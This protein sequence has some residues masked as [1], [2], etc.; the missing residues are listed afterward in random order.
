MSNDIA[1][2]PVLVKAIAASESRFTGSLN[3]ESEKVFAYDAITKNDNLAKVAMSNPETLKLAMYN[4]AAVG[5]TLNPAQRFAYLITR[6]LNGANRVILDIS[7]KGMIEI[8]IKAGSIESCSVTLLHEKDLETFEWID[9]FTPPKRAPNPFARNRGEIVGGYCQARLPNGTWKLSAMNIDQILKRRDASPAGKSQYGPWANWFEE[10]C[11]KTIVR[12]A[13]RFWPS[14]GS[15]NLEEAQRILNEENGEGL[16]KT[17]VIQGE[18]VPAAE[19]ETVVAT[20]PPSL[21]VQLEA[22]PAPYSKDEVPERVVSWI[23]TCASRAVANN[24][25]NTCISAFR[26]KFEERD[27]AM[28]AYALNELKTKRDSNTHAA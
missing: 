1:L 11:M 23:D 24:A 17:A 15:S 4:C 22:L 6:K 9:D 7:Y 18:V 12:N 25:F 10:M 20:P 21:D 5:L 19:Q 3:Y 27:A 28:Y 14:N 2:Q 13:A 26:A 16:E 8:A